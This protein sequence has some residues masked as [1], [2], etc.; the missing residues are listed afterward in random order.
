MQ[1]LRVR[2]SSGR[3]VG[4][5]RG[6]QDTQDAWLL[7]SFFVFFGGEGLHFPQLRFV[8]SKSTLAQTVD[9]V[10]GRCSHTIL[11]L[12]FLIIHSSNPFEISLDNRVMTDHKAAT[13]LYQW[14]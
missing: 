2:M 10:K 7:A 6:K 11:K 13:I 5:L 9:L 4:G 14:Y 3:R 1:P 8:N 12:V